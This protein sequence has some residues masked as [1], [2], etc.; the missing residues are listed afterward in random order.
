MSGMPELAVLTGVAGIG[1]AEDGWDVAQSTGSLSA[2]TVTITSPA[3]PTPQK[4]FAVSSSES[5]S[6]LVLDGVVDEDDPN[7]IV[8]ICSAPVSRQQRNPGGSYG[9]VD[10]PRC[11]EVGLRSLVIE[12]T[13]AAHLMARFKEEATL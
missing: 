8:T 9:R 4:L 7:T 2:G 11:R 6:R 5:L 1:R 3:S 13:S 12:A 10:N